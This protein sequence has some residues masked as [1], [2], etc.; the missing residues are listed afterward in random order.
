MNHPTTLQYP[1]AIHVIPVAKIAYYPMTRQ[2]CQ[3]YEAPEG[4]Y[5]FLNGNV[6]TVIPAGALLSTLEDLAVEEY[7]IEHPVML[8]LTSTEFERAMDWIIEC[9]YKQ[10]V[11]I[12]EESRVLI[13]FSN[14]P[15]RFKNYLLS[16]FSP[17]FHV[18]QLE[19]REKTDK[20]KNKKNIFKMAY[21]IFG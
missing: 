7:I 3:Q 12:Y 19:K 18:K 16:E 6:L 10:P 1:R 5:L 20:I 9:D 11:K 17:L 13:F 2:E 15:E 21:S 4:S 8:Q 14:D